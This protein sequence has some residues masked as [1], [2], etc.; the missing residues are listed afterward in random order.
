MT[1]QVVDSAGLAAGADALVLLDGAQGLGAVPT[2]VKMDC[3]FYAASGQNGGAVPTAVG[4]CTCAMSWPRAARAV[5]QLRSAGRQHKGFRARCHPRA[6]RFAIGFPAPHQVE[7]ALSALDV[8]RRTASTRSTRAGP[9]WPAAWPGPRRTGG[10]AR[11]LA[12]VSWEGRRPRGDRGRLR[13]DGLVVRN[14]P[15]PVTWGVLGAWSSEDEL[16]R[17]VELA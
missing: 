14:L 2:H 10:A 9:S 7:W 16:D 1:G 17:L 6:R 15:G 5:A 12:L 4:Y 8:P 11:A 3:D 13:S